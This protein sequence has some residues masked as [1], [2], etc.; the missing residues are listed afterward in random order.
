MLLFDEPR[1]RE[2]VAAALIHSAGLGTVPGL[3]TNPVELRDELLNAWRRY[4]AALTREGTVVAWIEDLHWAEPEIVRLLDRLTFGGDIRLLVLGTARPEFAGSAALRPGDD[5]VLLDLSPLDEKAALA[6]ARSA[7]AADGHGIDRAAGNPLFIVELARSRAG[8]EDALPI[9]LHGAIAARLDELPAADRDLLQ[10][11]A[12]IGETLGI[13]DVALLTDRTQADVAGALARLVHGA[14]LAPVMGG[15]R[16]HHALVHEVAYGR[17]PVAERM[18]LH[19]RYAREGVRPEDAEALAH[20]WWE[21]LRPP[22]AEWV[23]EGSPDLPDMR[24]EAFAAHL[25]AG[26][27]LVDRFAHER[28]VEAL[29][30]ALEFAT[31]PKDVAETERALGIAYARHGLGD[32]AWQHRMRAIVTYR[33]AGVAA[34]AG[35][36]AETLTIPV[37]NYAFTKTLPE[38]ALVLRLLEEGEGAAREQ[39]DGAALARLLLL[40]GYYTAEPDKAAEAGRIADAAADPLPYTDTLARLAMVQLMAGDIEG[41]AETYA[42]VDQLLTAGGSIDEPEFL[43]YRTTAELLQGHIDR[44]EWFSQRY[45]A[46]SG[47]LGPHLR[48]HALQGPASTGMARG[49]WPRA[50]AAALDV[51]RIVHENSDTPFC[52]RGAIAAACGAAASAIEGDRASAERLIALIDR[53]LP[54]P[55]PV[56]AVALALP[57]AMLGH[58]FDPR[59]SMPPAGAPVR[60]WHR[61]HADPPLQH[62]AIALVIQERWD[63]LGP[64][65]DHLDSFTRRGSPFARALAEA[66]REESAAARGAARPRHA[67]LKGLGFHGISELLSYRPHLSV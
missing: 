20:H 39:G 17:L 28:A 55:G 61:Q 60:P 56:R 19:A 40:D 67:A 52:T 27:R 37:M 2:R 5:R 59:E 25:A 24:R 21:A 34:P 31:D 11:A 9:N 10:H 14:Y 58:A 23:W 15:F 47:G 48:T 22:D 18:R 4:L 7:G 16:F 3:P 35:L 6:L 33:D 13:R 41:V 43:G 1:E 29:R 57:T 30:R 63:E 12:I 32:D 26:R 46:L 8:H 36:Y 64:I 54:R 53:I 51:E 50:V 45:I 65:L 62:V 44:S 49:D 66:V 38:D 42:R